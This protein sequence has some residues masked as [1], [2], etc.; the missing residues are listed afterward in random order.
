MLIY[1]DETSAE[2]HSNREVVDGLKSLVGELQ[3]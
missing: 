1:V 3:Q 2:F